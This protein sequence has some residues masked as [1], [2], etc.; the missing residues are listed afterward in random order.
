MTDNIHTAVFLMLGYGKSIRY[1]H[2]NVRHSLKGGVFSTSTMS[3]PIWYDINMIS[4]WYYGNAVTVIS[5]SFLPSTY[6]SGRAARSLGCSCRWW[7]A[8][9][10]LFQFYAYLLEAWCCCPNVSLC[11]F[12]LRGDT[13]F[14]KPKIWETVDMFGLLKAVLWLWNNH[15]LLFDNVPL[16]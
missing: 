9:S 7:A 8:W 6:W 13:T 15:L 3:V 2:L 5:L 10:W 4:V 16:K 1:F 14:C 11:F 12:G